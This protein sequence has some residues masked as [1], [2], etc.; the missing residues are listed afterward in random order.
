METIKNAVM[1]F[2]LFIGMIFANVVWILFIILLVGKLLYDKF[3]WFSWYH[4]SVIGTPIEVLLLS[5]FL[6]FIALITILV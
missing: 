1:V 6:F 3:V 2:F 4:L 5:M